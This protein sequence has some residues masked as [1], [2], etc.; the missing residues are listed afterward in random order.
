M[1]F[2]SREGMSS[3]ICRDCSTLRSP[4]DGS[5][6][7]THWKE[8]ANS[9]GPD[10][11]EGSTSGYNSSKDDAE[12]D[13]DKEPH[14]AG[15][16][17]CS[18]CDKSFNPSTE[19]YERQP[20]TDLKFLCSNCSDKNFGANSAED[21]SSKEHRMMEH[22]AHHFEVNGYHEGDP[23]ELEEDFEKVGKNTQAIA[24][25]YFKPLHAAFSKIWDHK[26]PKINAQHH[27]DIHRELLANA[28]AKVNRYQ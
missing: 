9:V 1:A 23:G 3:G 18:N 20:G 14:R 12:P 7:C 6:A 28:A 10:L 24:H 15:L 25:E 21:S 2:E 26:G 5:C 8:I 13:I 4:H 11:D 17:T 19:L 22:A 27:T 16:W